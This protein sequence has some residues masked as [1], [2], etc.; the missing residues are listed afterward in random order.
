MREFTW[1][2][3]FGAGLMY[4]WIFYG[5]QLEFAYNYTLGWREKAVQDTRGYK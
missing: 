1:G 2:T 4:Y 5:H 3:L